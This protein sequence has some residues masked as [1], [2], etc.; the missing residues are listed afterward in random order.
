MGYLVSSLVVFLQGDVKLVRN[1]CM[2]IQSK[3]TKH[4]IE[5][6]QNLIN[7]QTMS[8]NTYRV[9]QLYPS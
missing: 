2:M 4:Q 5:Y 6:V 1:L 8:F 7:P 3:S 9:R